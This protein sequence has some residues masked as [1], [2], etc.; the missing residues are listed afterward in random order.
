MKWEDLLSTVAQEP[1]FSSALLLTLARDP[2]DVRKQLSR[3]VKVGKLIQLRRGLYALAEPYRKST[4]SPFLIANRLREPSYVS[5][6]SALAHYGL[7]PEYVP[8]VTSVTTAKP[9]EIVTP[10]EQFIY[11][12]CKKSFFH[13]Y[14][15]LE[16][17]QGQA[18]FV[19]VPEKALL[20]L[21]H[22]TPG[23]DR[24][25]FL[26][27]LRLQNSDLLDL[28]VMQRMAQ[29]SRSPKLVRAAERVARLAE[30]EGYESL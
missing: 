20:D 14:S 17:T 29:K 16:L 4:P 19:A 27:E 26:N 7:I 13:G 12:H 1:V 3:W 5:L 6:Q 15:E 18:A 10:L 22:L 28:G 25:E 24:L 2:A 23:G 21:V 9:G 30:G 8:A 11:R